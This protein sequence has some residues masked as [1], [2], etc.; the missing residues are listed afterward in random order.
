MGV[1][2]LVLSLA[3]V[4]ALLVAGCGAGEP[5]A[6]GVS[7]SATDPP[8]PTTPSAARLYEADGTV[9]EADDGPML[10]LGGVLLMY[11]PQCGDIPI[12]NWDWDAVEGEET[13]A[14]AIWGDFHLVGTFDGGVFTVSETGPSEPGEEFFGTNP[15]FTPPCPEPEGGWV[16]VDPGTAS[17][18]DF[19]RGSSRAKALP[20]FVA[21]WVEHVGNPTPEEIE[22]LD[23]EGKPYPQKIMNV[24]VT[25]DVAAAEAAIREAWGGPLCVVRR[26]G[27]TAKELRAIRAEAERWLQDELGLRMTWSGE[28]PLG[29]YAAE[30]GV[31]IDPGG[32]GQAALDERYGP[33]MVR[34]YPALRPVQ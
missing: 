18:R 9:F 22:R 30:V 27:H 28:G 4:P 14:G 25:G 7:T 17:E 34:L 10:C 26:E 1:R 15:D 33:G 16:D 29:Q 12:A 19:D 20:D 6:V 3:A 11:P 13:G 2:T 8:L 5:G 32:A 31:W 24:V 23:R 21:L